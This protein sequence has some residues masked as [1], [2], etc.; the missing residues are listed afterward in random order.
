MD[1]LWTPIAA[2]GGHRNSER[3][4]VQGIFWKWTRSQRIR[5]LAEIPLEVDLADNAPPP[6]YQQIATKAA[7]LGDEPRDV[8]N[9]MR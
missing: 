5:T 4:G 1:R 8:P 7:E 2:P 3:R 9:A 6:V